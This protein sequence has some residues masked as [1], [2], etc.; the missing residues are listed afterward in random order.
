MDKPILVLVDS[1]VDM[2]HPKLKDDTV[3]Q[4]EIQGTE[5]ENPKQN[6]HGTAI[7]GILRKVR[8]DFEIISIK[9]RGI[10]NGVD[11]SVLCDALEY[12]EQNINAALI[13]LSLGS[14]MLDEKERLEEICS[15][16]TEKG[17]VIVSAFDNAGVISYPAAFK[18]VI[19][20]VSG[21]GCRSVDEY[22]IFNDD[23]MNI[24]GKGDLQRLMWNS[25]PVLLLEGNSFAC[26]HISVI[27]AKMI[28]AGFRTKDAILTELKRRASNVTDIGKDGKVPRLDFKIEKAAVFP[29]NKEMHALFRYHDLLDFSIA[30]VYDSKYSARVGADTRFLL[31]DEKALALQIRNI[32]SIDWDEFDTLILGHTDEMEAVTG[33]IGY[34]SGLLD[35]AIALGKNIYTFDEIPKLYAVKNAF[36]QKIDRENLPCNRMGMLYR[37]PKPVLAVCGTSSK[38]GK[39]TLQ[40]ELRK[41]LLKEGYRVGQIGTEPNA[42]LLGLDHVFPMGYNSAV[43]LS[44]AES[45]LYLN[46]LMNDLSDKDLIIVGM[47]SGTVTYDFGNIANCCICQ[48]SFLMGTQPDAVVLCVNS[49]DELDYI[50]RT[51]RYLEASVESEV[52]ALVLYPMGFSDSWAGI[53]GSRVKVKEERV[54]ELA[55]IFREKFDLP[56]Y[57]LGKEEDMEALK[58]TVIDFFAEEE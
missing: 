38:Q 40:L 43:H 51:I 25:P 47:Q 57:L 37:I 36:T 52:V 26:A 11:G 19:G 9:I 17:T 8:E 16:M 18:S 31:K 49:Y 54:C 30:A 12:I 7:Y 50:E 14:P 5:E 41:R 22:M 56:L 10:E 58:N 15:R 28:K 46:S 27:A 29:F 45:I 48:N 33:K 44:E 32:D 6:G 53:Y 24:A 21:P 20:V 35:K 55:E 23:V 4:I 1:G 42:L 13:N 2:N 3:R 34:S 39:F